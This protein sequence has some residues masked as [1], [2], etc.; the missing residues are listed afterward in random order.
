MPLT[1]NLGIQAAPDHAVRDVDYTAT[2]L[3]R[4]TIPK[5]KAS[6]QTTITITPKNKGT[7]I[8]RLVG[9][10]DPNCHVRCRGSSKCYR[11]GR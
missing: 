2:N 10:R 11:L 7:G 4:I 5:N 6:G 9:K 3:G 1:F 8:I